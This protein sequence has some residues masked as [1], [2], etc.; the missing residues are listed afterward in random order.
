M[1]GGNRLGLRAGGMSPPAQG[2]P[3]T[4]FDEAV[5][6]HAL[7]GNRWR[8][9]ADRRHESIS[10]MFG[11]WTAATL[12]QAVLNSASAAGSTATPAALTVHFV[13][14]ITPG[15][16]VVLTVARLGGGRSLAFWRAELIPA[17]GGRVLA[18][19]VVTLVNRRESD[20][21]VESR[22]PE[23]P[24]PSS[25]RE[26]HAPGSQG[27]QTLIR[28]I[29]GHPPTKT[30]STSSAAWV[31]LVEPRPLDHTL[32]AYLADQF[33]PRSFYWSDEP[34]PSATVTLSVYFH[35]T[36]DEL[37]AAGEDYVLNEAIGTRG[38]QSTSG[39]QLRMWSRAGALL[40]TSEQ[41]CWY[42]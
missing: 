28:P 34:R 3:M 36:V 5:T 40:A 9:H 14:K 16:D 15:E 26:F 18:H 6:L 19:A 24:D 30:A 20:G 22:M 37:A 39:A 13:D 25:L 23:A 21:H 42:R 29:W 1:H 27:Q 11:G 10:G 31:Q 41:L 7:E 17:D 35:A 38:E 4:S 32:L 2:D 33:A 8:G 12:L